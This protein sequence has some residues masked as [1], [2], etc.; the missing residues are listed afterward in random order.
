MNVQAVFDNVDIE[1]LTHL[2]KAMQSHEID[3]T[4]QTFDLMNLICD[5]SVSLLLR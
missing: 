5:S 4:H 3:F 1:S 2:L